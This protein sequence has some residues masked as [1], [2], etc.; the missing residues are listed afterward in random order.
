MVQ[1]GE[2][3]AHAT[4]GMQALRGAGMCSCEW[5]TSM[6]QHLHACCCVHCTTA[7]A[8]AAHTGEIGDGKCF[9]SPV[10]D[11]VRM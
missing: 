4:H 10:A 6:Q 11:V 5:G 8:I 3:A 9:V 1:T 2:V 7:V